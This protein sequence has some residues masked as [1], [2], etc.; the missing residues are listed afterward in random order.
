[1]RVI[2]IKRP[3]LGA[4]G[5]QM[6]HFLVGQAYEMSPALA[7]LMIAAGWV[8]A[9]SRSTSRRS[10]LVPDLAVAERRQLPDRRSQTHC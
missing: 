3:D 4:H 5:I 7:F 9:Q 6:D 10:L 1:M 8:R 2:V